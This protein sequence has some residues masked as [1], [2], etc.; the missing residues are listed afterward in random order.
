MTMTEM[1]PTPKTGR[2]SAIVVAAGG[3][4]RMGFNKLLAPLAGTPVLRRTLAAFEAC[5]AVDEVFLIAGDDVAAVVADWRAEPG[6][7]KLRAVLPGGAERHF[8]VWAGLQALA[9]GG[10]L[11]AVHDGARPLIRPEQIARCVAAADEHGAA[12]CARP[13]TETIKRVDAAGQVTEALDRE[14]VWVME[15]PQ[16]FRVELLRRAYEAV[17]AAG[18]L[19]T[20]EVSAVRHLGEPVR[21]VENAWP[22]PKITFAGDLELAGRLI[23]NEGDSPSLR[24]D[25]CKM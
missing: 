20:D 17:L 18:L 25:E 1:K 13:L 5:A 21:V 23:S 22:N 4:R 19:V 7:A 12:V 10:G 16:V 24:E 11:V 14:G 8:S 6:L 2:V 9:G 15:T 3:S